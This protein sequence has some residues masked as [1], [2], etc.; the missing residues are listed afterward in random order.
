M[1]R[2]EPTIEFVK[3]YSIALL[4]LGVFLVLGAL[5][6]QLASR[7]AE[8]SSSSTFISSI[9]YLLGFSC[10]AVSLLRWARASAALPATAAL[11]LCLLLA[12]PLGTG[13]SI[14][15]LTRVKPRETI[16]REV[17]E[18]A[19]FNYT[20]MLY[21]L[22]LLMLDAALVF[23]F[24]LGSAGSED[25]LLSFI[26][27][28]LFVVAFAAIVIGALRATTLPWVH[29]ATFILN[30]LLA[31]WFPLGTAVALVWFLAFRKHERELLSEEWRHNA[32]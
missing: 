20:V 16:S 25:Q 3:G 13:L 7:G 15:W 23:R 29:W 31:L 6:F 18:R 10:L 19:W 24:V 27:L 9:L 4:C 28:G 1:N 21:I 22:G 8:D 32:A 5:Q 2:G 17:S 26:E 12:F 14:Y 30:V 11:S